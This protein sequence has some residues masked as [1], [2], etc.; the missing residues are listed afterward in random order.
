M[1]S[2]NT[3]R[4]FFRKYRRHISINSDLKVAN[5][6]LNNK[7]SFSSEKTDK[8]KK[9][10]YNQ[11]VKVNNYFNFD[12]EISQSRKLEFEKGVPLSLGFVDNKIFTIPF[13]FK[14]YISFIGKKLSET[15]L[16]ICIIVV[17]LYYLVSF[18][19]DK[20]NLSDL[21]LFFALSFHLFILFF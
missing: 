3:P 18:L 11:L 2:I 6:G 20:D 14:G 5:G 19:F 12:Q 17:F 10:E 8:L 9:Q 1:S 21:N 15:P 4:N 13:N 16:H 7:D